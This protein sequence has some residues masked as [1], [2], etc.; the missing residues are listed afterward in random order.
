M[1]I[2][3]INLME[4]LDMKES[5]N[6]KGAPLAM[7]HPIALSAALPDASWKQKQMSSIA[8]QSAESGLSLVGNKICHAMISRYPVPLD[9]GFIASC[10]HENGYRYSEQMSRCKMQEQLTSIPLNLHRILF[11]E[12]R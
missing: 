7:A 1:N 11:F 10:G 2:V 3:H 6:A 8:N 5:P 12:K 9:Y 4:V